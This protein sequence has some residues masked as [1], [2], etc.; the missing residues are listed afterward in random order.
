MRFFWG[1]WIVFL[2]VVAVFTL[3]AFGG[4]VHWGLDLLANGRPQMLIFAL[5]LAV[6]FAL[7]GRW[8]GC[9]WALLVG[10]VNALVVL[11]YV[12]REPQMLVSSRNGEVR[13]DEPILRV[14][15][16][17]VLQVNH[18]GRD[19]QKLPRLLARLQPDVV[20]LQ[21]SGGFWREMVKQWNVQFPQ[22][23]ILDPKVHHHELSLLSSQRVPWRK[24]QRVPLTRE[25]KRAGLAVEFEWQGRTVSLLTVHSKRPTSRENVDL[26]R[27]WHEAIA[28][29]VR[30]KKAQG[31]AVIVMGD[32]NCT[33]WMSIYREFIKKLDLYEAGRGNPFAATWQNPS[34]VRLMID[35]IFFSEDW[36]LLSWKVMD[37]VDSDHRPV[38]VNLRLRDNEY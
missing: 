9:G 13:D 25:Y 2:V 31:H 3:L 32:F 1:I 4:R 27:E 34:P 30:Q 12:W 36:Q 22:I 10:A 20:G 15:T 21:E 33:P 16:A 29:W 37:N 7:G 11:P 28:D 35:H 17:N 26:I 19:Y 5:F 18:P 38:M 14:V 23:S 6:V 24:L 8:K